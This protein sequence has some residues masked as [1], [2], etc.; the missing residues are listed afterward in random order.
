MD[1]STR[2]KD[3]LA[4]PVI[5]KDSLICVD[6]TVDGKGD[7]ESGRVSHSQGCPWGYVPGVSHIRAFTARLV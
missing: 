3:A 5:S 1:F 7:E 6:D 2:K 4:I